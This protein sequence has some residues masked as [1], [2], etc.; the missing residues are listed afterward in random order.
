V[1]FSFYPLTI[2]PYHSSIGFPFSFSTLSFI[3]D[4]LLHCLF[5]HSFIHSSMRLLTCTPLLFI[6]P[7]IHPFINSSLELLYS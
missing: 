4:T 6:H 3:L 7:F 5:I 2:H 1:N